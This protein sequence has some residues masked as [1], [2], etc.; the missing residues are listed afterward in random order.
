MEAT[1]RSPKTEEK[2]GKKRPRATIV[3]VPGVL[4]YLDVELAA[5]GHWPLDGFIGFA[6]Q[7]RSRTQTL[8]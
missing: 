1:L 2:L 4:E 7:R 5:M 3:G 6:P 8:P